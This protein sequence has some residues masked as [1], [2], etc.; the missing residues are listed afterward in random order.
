MT[1]DHLTLS[2][3]VNWQMPLPP[4]V[5]FPGSA[6]RRRPAYSWHAQD[7]LPALPRCHSK[8]QR[9]GLPRDRVSTSP[10][11]VTQAS[12]SLSLLLQQHPDACVAGF[13]EASGHG[14]MDPA[15]TAGGVAG[16]IRSTGLCADESSSKDV[17][18]GF[19]KL[20]TQLQALM[21][22]KNKLDREQV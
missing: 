17:A 7:K 18:A 15:A 2:S 3:T 1:P 6:R 22:E 10:G 13:V 21:K 5:C 12:S 4:H 11:E 8:T 14:N 20:Q 19:V 16:S 9:P